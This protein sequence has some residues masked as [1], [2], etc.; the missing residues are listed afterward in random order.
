MDFIT[1]VTFVLMGVLIVVVLPTFIMHRM[2]AQRS[3]LLVQGAFLLTLGIA[4]LFLALF[5]A[6]GGGATGTEV[7][8]GSVLS[9]AAVSLKISVILI[10][11]ALASWFLSVDVAGR[12]GQT[13]DTTNDQ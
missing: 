10:L 7:S 9:V 5:A 3:R 2:K 13:G 6:R 8:P 12:G 11:G 4:A 1:E